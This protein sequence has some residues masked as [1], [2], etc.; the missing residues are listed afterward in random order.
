MNYVFFLFLVFMKFSSYAGY[1]EHSADSAFWFVD[2]A[3][4]PSAQR[5]YHHAIQ[6]LGEIISDQILVLSKKQ[7]T[8]RSPFMD[9]Q[10]NF[11]SFAKKNY[12]KIIYGVYS[13]LNKIP[14]HQ[15]SQELRPGKDILDHLYMAYHSEQKNITPEERELQ[16][17]FDEIK[18]STLDP[19][20]IPCLRV[21]LIDIPTENA[22]NTGCHIFISKELYQVVSKDELLAILAHELGHSAHGDGIHSFL[23]T[24]SEFATHGAFLWIDEMSWFL[25][26]TQYE[27][28]EALQNGS[29]LEMVINSIGNAAPKVEKNADIMGVKSL[30]K[31]KKNP[32]LLSQALI[33]LTTRRQASSTAPSSVRQY[34]DLQARL[35][36]IEAYLRTVNK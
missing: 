10:S 4:R 27:H 30:L 1:L 20:M 18:V 29:F 24:Q 7:N 16:K 15:L 33:K 22:F 8:Q 32:R 26:G 35:Q 3:I 14:E 28:F 23:L 9:A 6:P 11:P 36:N 2:N 34:P 12:E 31:A 25:T 13:F 17:I 21:H 19:D 5:L